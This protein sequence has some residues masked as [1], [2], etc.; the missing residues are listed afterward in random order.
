[1]PMARAA[2]GVR[3]MTRP[4]TNGP[5]SLMVTRTDL[6]LLLLVT[7]AR[8]PHG[9]DLCAAVSA[10][11][12][13]DPPQATRVPLSRPYSVAMPS[14]ALAE[15]MRAATSAAIRMITQIM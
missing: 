5:L 10:F 13:S 8:E 4:R 14:S 2:A 15:L 9:K 1:M 11:S 3:S 6:P 7:R 12:L